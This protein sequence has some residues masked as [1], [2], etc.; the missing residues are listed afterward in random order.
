MRREDS[1]DET[2]AEW[3]IIS[4][5]SRSDA[6]RDGVLVDVSDV[7]REAGFRIPVAMT[8]AAWAQTVHV[9]AGLNCQDE[10]GRLWDVLSVLRF[11]IKSSP[12]SRDSSLIEFTVSVRTGEVTSEDV[13]LKSICC[14][15]DNAELVITVMLP[16]ED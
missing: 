8:S 12:S 3:E 13:R 2:T 6:I 4:S 14:P 10:Q 5:Y 15:G 7:A 1:K 16:G 9:S 11:V